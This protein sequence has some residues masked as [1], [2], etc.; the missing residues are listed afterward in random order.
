EA[1][2]EYLSFGTCRAI[3]LPQK[4]V[5]V[6]RELERVRQHDQIE[7][8]LGERKPMRIGP[9]LSRRLRRHGPARRNS[10]LREKGTRRQAELNRMKTEDVGDRPIE[11]SLLACESVATERGFEPIGECR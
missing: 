8:I 5:R 4:L 3:D 2:E 10:A 11:P 9:Y 1:G 7:R 6:A